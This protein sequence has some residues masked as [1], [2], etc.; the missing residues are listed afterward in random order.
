MSQATVVFLADWVPPIALLAAL[1]NLLWRVFE[2]SGK[3]FDFQWLHVFLPAIVLA[4]VLLVLHLLIYLL[5]PLRWKAIREQFHGELERRIRA[6]LD[7]V[8]R[9]APLEV[10]EEL[11]RERQQVEKLIADTGEVSAWLAGREQSAN[12]GGLYGRG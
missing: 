8:Y 6:E 7:S 4:V 9:S 1:G 5:L 10:A 11:K 12:I 2:P 3:S